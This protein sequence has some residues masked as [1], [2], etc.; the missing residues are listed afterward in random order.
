MKYTK[1]IILRNAFDVFMEKGYDSA[2]ISVLQKELNMSRGA[3]YC[4]FKNKEDLFC[5]VIDQYFFRIFN[6]IAQQKTDNMTVP[7]LIEHVY[8]RHRLTVYLFNKGGISHDA[9]LNYTALLIQGAKHYP[10]F[11]Q[12]YRKLRTALMHKWAIALENSLKKKEIKEDTN[13]PMMCSLFNSVFSRETSDETCEDNKFSLRILEDID[14]RK[15]LLDYLY[16]LIKK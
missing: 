16:S 15:L 11:I 2:S 13:I 7:E 5:S 4:Y 3:M 8:K 12:K 1:E 10:N 9:F 6:K 14:N